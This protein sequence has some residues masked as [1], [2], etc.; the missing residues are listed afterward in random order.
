MTGNSSDVSEDL[1]ELI[2]QYLSP[3]NARSVLRRA[4]RR[5]GMDPDH[6]VPTQLPRLVSTLRSSFT[7]FLPDGEATALATKI[8]EFA[9]DDGDGPRAERIELNDETDLAHARSLAREVAVGL[10]G[11]AFAAQRVATAVSELG[12]NI[13]SYTGRGYVT[14]TTGGSSRI[15]VEAVDQGKRI[16][17][18]PRAAWGSVWPVPDASW[19]SSR[20]TPAPAELAS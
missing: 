7:L 16:D 3:I 18:A 6:I 4:A 13:I 1:T 15:R 8:L 14:M 12:R 5:V 9:Q 17:T 11:S 19:T 2:G 20:S 10:G